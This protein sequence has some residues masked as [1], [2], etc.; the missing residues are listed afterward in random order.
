ME[1]IDVD[2]KALLD[3]AP[4]AMIIVDASGQIVF[5]NA[6]TE[7][8]FG[9]ERRELVGQ[10]VETLLPD[11]FRGP[12]V[13]HREGYFSSPK[14]RP[15]GTELDL[16]GLRKDGSEFP[17]EISLS[18]VQTVSGTLVSSAIRDIS[19]RKEV[20][21]A[22]I[23]ARNEAER[24]NREKSAF[25]AA[26]SHDLRQPI[27]TLTLLNA[28]LERTATDARAAKAVYRQAEALGTMADSLNA[29]LDISKIESGAIK[30]DVADHG[31][32]RIF[33]RLRLAFELQAEA[34]GLKLLVDDCEDVVRSDPNLLEQIIQNL[35]SNAIRYT[36]NG[37]VQLRCRHFDGD[38]RIEVLDTGIGIPVNE[39]DMI[40]E[41]FYQLHREPGE[42]RE[43]LG[44]GLSIVQRL[45]R[46]L[47]HSLQVEST[48]GAG[49]CFS[50]T[51]P[52]GEERSV[53]PETTV[54]A[55][56]APTRAGKVLI[57]DDDPAVADAAAMLLEVEGH[58]VMLASTSEEAAT[59]VSARG[60]P[61][62]IVADFHLGGGQTGVD[63]IERLRT[64]AGHAIPAL[65]VTGDTS[66]SITERIE[67]VEPCRVLPKP[68]DANEL[69]KVIRELTSVH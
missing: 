23:A 46:L 5:A 69:I 36:K 25:L 11:R 57:I 19:D 41:D 59:V 7:T 2:V 42:R 3:S 33:S 64:H 52:R 34:K 35:L 20:Q 58:E 38:V 31:V 66:S 50:V 37:L 61:D 48:P 29:L 49:T 4:D 32:Q 30:P 24:A 9:F 1:L 65:I 67:A 8:L 40:F 45:T 13:A 10:P 53:E 43:G 68:V 26:A 27:Q 44:L 22:L 6:Q 39:L 15:M 28:V 14:P 18:A 16:F 47:E 60:M 62:I 56:S 63:A 54:V 17:I 21:R 55:S 12:H 51:V